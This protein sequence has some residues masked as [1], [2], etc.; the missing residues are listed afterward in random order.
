M[1]RIIIAEADATGQPARGTKCR[2]IRRQARIHIADTCPPAEIPTE[3]QILAL[4]RSF[5]PF[6][7]GCIIRAT[8]IEKYGR[9]QCRDMID[10]SLPY[11]VAY[12]P[13]TDPVWPF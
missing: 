13:D 12:D 1:Y 2:G 3:A 7:I 6:R 4:L 8:A 9:T 10:R 11:V 5:K